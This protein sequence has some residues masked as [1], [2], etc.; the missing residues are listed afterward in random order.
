[1]FGKRKTAQPPNTPNPTGRRPAAPVTRAAAGSREAARR[2]PEGAGRT[3]VSVRHRQ[4]ASRRAEH[5]SPVILGFYI[6]VLIT[7]LV[8]VGA[9][10]AGASV[11][12]ALLRAGVV[13]LLC[14]VIG[15]AVNVVL[16]MAA[17]QTKVPAAADAPAVQPGQHLNVVAGE[18][19]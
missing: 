2:A 18:D 5:P 9:F 11:E 6:V 16:W 17:N 4:P 19:E 14:T 13:L 10:S 7:A 3:Q 12:G 1:V 8:G 15:Y